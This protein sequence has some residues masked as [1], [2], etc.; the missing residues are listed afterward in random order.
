MLNSHMRCWVCAATLSPRK[1][2]SPVKIALWPFLFSKLLDVSAVFR[3]FRCIFKSKLLCKQSRPIKSKGQNIKC[4]CYHVVNFSMM[5][6][7]LYRENSTCVS[8]QE[9]KLQVKLPVEKK[10]PQTVEG[11]RTLFWTK[12][13]R[14]FQRLPRTHFPFFKDSVQCKKEIWVYVFFS[15]TTT[16]A[17]LSWK[18]FILGTWEF[19][20]DKVSTE[21]QRLSSTDCNFQGLSRPW[22]FY[23]KFQGL[24]RS[25]KVRANPV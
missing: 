6:S 2:G 25:F 17:I 10:H 13:S 23:F 18:S 19:G 7:A 1:F 11:V 15:S 24:S 9:V 4:R 16:W 3:S 20:L 21:I 12:T 5:A 14:T 22:T 8:S